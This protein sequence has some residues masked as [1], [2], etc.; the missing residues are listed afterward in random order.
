MGP[1]KLLYWLSANRE[2]SWTRFRSAVERI[3]HSEPDS[4]ADAERL[5][6]FQR[7]RFN[8][9]Q[10]AHV[11][12][13]TQGCEDGWRV[14]PPVLAL[15]PQRDCVVGILC[16]ARLPQFVRTLQ[17]GTSHVRLE[18]HE[19]PEHPDVIRLVSEDAS[20]LEEAAR[21]V[22]AGIQFHAA[23]A[24]LSCL[25]RIS[26]LKGWHATEAELPRGRDWKVFRF[27]I[28]RKVCKWVESSVQEANQSRTGLFRFMRFQREH[29]LRLDGRTYRVRGQLG[30]FY[31]L[32]QRR[33]QLLRYDRTTR[34]LTVPSV[35][36]P[37]VLVDR[38][39][40]LCSGFLPRHDADE[41]LLTYG[42]VP[43]GIAGLAATI[44]CQESV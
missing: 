25:P 1:N 3:I 13:D 19:G 9:Q 18:R 33:R 39:L 44:L 36:R 11:E 10:L 27:E 17:K 6:L 37:P 30:N 12:F 5:P 20:R 42:D 4:N 35:C 34:D 41:G 43:E 14:A 40:V 31:L 7:L 24:I 29:Y 2:G 26:D 8:L 15:A 22:G 21:S 16:G 38:A 28:A 23:L 32:A